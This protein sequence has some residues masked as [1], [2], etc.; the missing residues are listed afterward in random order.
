MVDKGCFVDQTVQHP[1]AIHNRLRWV[2][3]TCGIDPLTGQSAYQR[4]GFAWIPEQGPTTVTVNR[5]WQPNVVQEQVPITQLVARQVTRKVPVQVCKYVDEVVVQKVPLQVCRM[6]QEEQVRKVPY[7]TCRQVT[8]RVECKVPVRVCRYVEEEIVR[9]IPVTTCRMVYEE[10]V[11]Q[12][13]VKVCKMVTENG[14][15]R[16][17]RV[18]NKQVPYTYTVQEPRT[19]VMRVPVDPCTGQVVEPTAVQRGVVVGASEGG[20]L[21]PVPSIAPET[22]VKKLPSTEQEPAA[23][24]PDNKELKEVRPAKSEPTP[25]VEGASAPAPQEKSVLL[26]P[27]DKAAAAEATTAPARS[28]LIPFSATKR[29]PLV[30]ETP[31]PAIDSNLNVPPLFD[32]NRAPVENPLKE[33]LPAAEPDA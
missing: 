6:V 24:S 1:G 21:T 13:P 32:E 26:P 28:N 16:T 20:A 19:V 14:T 5:I 8:E 33:E 22:T 23:P 29:Q 12:V 7:T 2:P 27:P 17:P 31:D 9:K 18:V 10:R 15:L 30:T 3:A 4:A 11:E 25:A